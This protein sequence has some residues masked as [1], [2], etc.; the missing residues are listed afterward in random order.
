MNQIVEDI[1]TR[2]ENGRPLKTDISKT[3]GFHFDGYLWSNLEYY[4]NMTINHDADC[5]GVIDGNEGTGKS[6]LAQQVAKALDVDHDIAP[7]QIVFKATQFNAVVRKLKKGK[8][9]VYD[10]SQEGLDRRNWQKSSEITHMLRVCRQRNLFLIMVAQ[11]FYD[12]D[13]R[14]AVRRSRFLL[15]V[16]WVPDSDKKIFTRGQYRFY[17]DEQK[18]RL[19]CSNETKKFYD[20][21]ARWANFQG[22][23]SNTYAT[24]EA[25]YR[26]RKREADFGAMSTELSPEEGIVPAREALADVSPLELK[27]L[28]R[29]E[30]LVFLWNLRQHAGRKNP[31]KTLK[32]YSDLMQQVALY[33]DISLRRLEQTLQEFEERLQAGRVASELLDPKLQAEAVFND[34][35]LAEPKETEEPLEPLSN[36]IMFQKISER[37]PPT[38][39]KVTGADVISVTTTG[40]PIDNPLITPKEEE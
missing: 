4:R 30:F 7:E 13:F 26:K 35:Q 40:H 29:R 34:N 39:P 21:P 18:K 33:L 11:S 25:E 22:K 16:Y 14:V 19:Y 2:K 20:Y 36:D 24:D 5:V 6:V 27:K 10:E 12:L 3:L 32:Q 37:L 8:A 31:P 1:P 15:H 23:F 28:R 9:I 38:T 17:S